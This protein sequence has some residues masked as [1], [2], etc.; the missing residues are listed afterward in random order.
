[1]SR[2]LAVILIINHLPYVELVNI[3]SNYSIRPRTGTYNHYIIL[4]MATNNEQLFK[5]ATDHKKP[6]QY[7]L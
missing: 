4:P 6:L 7:R 5:K 2:T 3:A 1:M